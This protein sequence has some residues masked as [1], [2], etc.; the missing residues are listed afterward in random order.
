MKAKLKLRKEVKELLLGIVV[1]LVIGFLW[2]IGTDYTNQQV[3]NCVN[4]G[5]SEYYCESHLKA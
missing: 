3:E 2:K 1:I 4:A 5:H